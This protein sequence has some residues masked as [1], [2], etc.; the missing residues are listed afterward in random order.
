VATGDVG[1]TAGGNLDLGTLTV[2]GD[3]T[4][5]S[6]NGSITSTGVLTVGGQTDLSAGTSISLT[7]SGNRFGGP[8]QFRGTTVS[9]VGSS[10]APSKPVVIYPEMDTTLRPVVQNGASLPA[11]KPAEKPQ[12]QVSDTPARGAWSAVT[13]PAT[14]GG[15]SLVIRSA[16]ESISSPADDIL[17]VGRAFKLD[18][19]KLVTRRIRSLVFEVESGLIAGTATFEFEG[20]TSLLLSADNVNGRVTITGEGSPEEFDKAV[21]TIV[22][23]LKDRQSKPNNLV[24]RLVMTDQAGAN[25]TKTVKLSDGS[26]R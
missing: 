3:L 21:R 14:G 25:E 17:P 11:L 8:A 15:D 23:R 13:V 1:L 19:E 9:V 24:I 7:N 22:L 16:S 10:L 20:G 5:T 4:A 2:G 18:T 6:T 26:I 12:T